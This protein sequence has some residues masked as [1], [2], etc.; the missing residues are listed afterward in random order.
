M[1]PFIYSDDQGRTHSFWFHV[2]TTSDSNGPTWEVRILPENNYFSRIPPY[3]AT[4]ITLSDSRVQSSVLSKSREDWSL[5]VSL[6]EAI[7]CFMSRM[8]K[9]PIVSSLRPAPPGES[10]R[11]DYA[12]KMWRRFHTD[13][14]ARPV[15]KENRYLFIPDFCNSHT[16]IDS[17]TLD[18]STPNPNG[19]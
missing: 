9:K 11:S 15:S 7:F 8:I 18:V 10:E 6:S 5:K 2:E 1:R 16:I 4:F 14:Y 17:S 19:R 13:G 12:D 3:E